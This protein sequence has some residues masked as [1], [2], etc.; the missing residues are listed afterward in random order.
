MPCQ[1]PDDDGVVV[2][3]VQWR[4]CLGCGA[5]LDPGD[6]PPGEWSYVRV[7]STGWPSVR[8]PA[9]ALVL[10]LITPAPNVAPFLAGP[11]IAHWCPVEKHGQVAREAVVEAE[12]IARVAAVES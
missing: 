7:P 6:F 9:G 5:E 4:P 11:V 1:Q 10:L 2:P 12:H 8:I 3:D